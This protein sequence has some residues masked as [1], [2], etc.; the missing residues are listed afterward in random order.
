[1]LCFS[2]CPLR[3][4]AEEEIQ[5][6]E[7]DCFLE[8]VKRPSPLVVHEKAGYLRVTRLS[9]S[10]RAIIASETHGHV[11]LQYFT[12]GQP[13]LQLLPPPPLLSSV[14]QPAH[15]SPPAALGVLVAGQ[16]VV[17]IWHLLDGQHRHEPL[18]AAADLVIAQ[19]RGAKQLHGCR[20]HTP[21][22]ATAAHGVCKRAADAGSNGE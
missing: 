13:L 21:L 18:V 8:L 16:V 19:D 9:S 6:A 3:V 11:P 10:K 12:G 4:D 7:F 20:P 5:L 14:Q 1:M 2:L 22:G 17:D 15:L